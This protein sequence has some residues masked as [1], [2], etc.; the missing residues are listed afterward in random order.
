MTITNSA[1]K[2]EYAYA[3]IRRRILDGAYPPGHRLVIRTLADEL[4]VSSV[5]VREAIRRLEAEGR[6]VHRH[7]AGSRVAPVD[8]RRDLRVG[9]DVGRSSVDA[10][11]MDGGDIAVAVKVP[12]TSDVTEGII[13]ALEGVMRDGHV[14]AAAIAAVVVGTGHVADAFVERRVAPVACIRLGLPATSALPPMVDWPDDTRAAIGVRCYLAHGGHEVDGRALSRID[15]AEL[16]LIATELGAHG[17]RAIAISAVFSPLVSQA[18]ERAAAILRAE[19]P[20]VD[21]TLS[22]RVGGLGLLERENAAI[23]NACV[24]AYA[25]A[26]VAGLRGALTRRGLIAPLYLTQND[27]ALM[28]SEAAE[29]YPVLTF[30]AGKANSMRGAAALTGLQDGVVIDVGGTTTEV[31]VLAHGFPRETE[32]P[33]LVG[34]VRTNIRVPDVRSLA[35]GGGSIVTPDPWRVGPASVGHA[36]LTTALV[37]GGRTVT[38]TDIAVAGG[39]ADIGDARHAACLARDASTVLDLAGELVRRAVDRARGGDE[40]TPVIMVGG[41]APLLRT[42]LPRYHPIIPERHAV[43]NAVGAA[44]APVSGRVD[45][46]VSLDGVSRRDMMASAV[47]DAVARA[48]MAGADATTVRIVSTEDAPLAYLPGNLTRVRVKAI[49]ALLAEDA[50]AR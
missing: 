32:E 48:I 4:G 20:G 22:H 14:A 15:E 9:I 5:P 43:A 40:H 34:G 45:R 2:Q 46:V 10:V 41:G 37:F 23:I 7:N 24:Q 44:T 50:R 3:A 16:R 35:I 42:L 6:V 13:A 21:I 11:L 18:E 8:G 29:Q 25:R 27:G 47:S 38:L 17:V 33:T 1:S 30:G 28:T 26:T 36:L 39:V 49:G 31:G 12:A 19:L